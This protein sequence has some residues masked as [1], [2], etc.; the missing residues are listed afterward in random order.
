MRRISKAQDKLTERLCDYGLAI[1]DYD[2][3]IARGYWTH[4]HQDCISW[5][6]SAQMSAKDVMDCPSGPRIGIDSWDSISD[7]A[8]YGFWLTPGSLGYGQYTAI[9]KNPGRKPPQDCDIITPE[10]FKAKHQQ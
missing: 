7:C 4:K 9:S 8:R 1:A 10:Q 3:E 6:L 2:F 5:E